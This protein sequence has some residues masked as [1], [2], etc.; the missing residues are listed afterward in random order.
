MGQDFEL[1]VDDL[2]LLESPKEFHKFLYSLHAEI[3]IISVDEMIQL[4][5]SQGWEIHVKILKEFEDI[6]L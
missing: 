3:I 5:D 6:M 4:Y 1:R 2:L